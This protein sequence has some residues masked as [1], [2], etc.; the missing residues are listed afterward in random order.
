MMYTKEQ[1]AAALDLA[2]LQPRATVED[3]CIAAALVAKE[4]IRSLCVAPCNIIYA[5]RLT[6]RVVAVIGFPH[7]NTMPAVKLYEATHAIQCGAIELDVVINYARLLEGDFQPVRNELLDIVGRARMSGVVVKAILETCYYSQHQI[8]DACKL[9]VD[10]GVDFVKTST[11]F[12]Q[13]LHAGGATPEAVRLML[14]AVGNRA[15]VKASGG[16]KTYADACRYLDLGC[17]RIGSS[18]YWELLP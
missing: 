10:C 9:C 13:G 11:G 2:V 3:V 8:Q 16:I 17:I 12:S 7:G 4:N 6:K 1:I 18:H 15:Q 5:R 14:E